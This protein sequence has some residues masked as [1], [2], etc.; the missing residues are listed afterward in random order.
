MKIIPIINY[1]DTTK[2]A[3][4]LERSSLDVTYSGEN[5]NTVHDDTNEVPLRE[6]ADRVSDSQEHSQLNSLDLTE[7]VKSPNRLEGL[8]SKEDLLDCSKHIK[9]TTDETSDSAK[10][11]DEEV[12]V[13]K[14]GESLRE[15]DQSVE[16]KSDTFFFFYY[17]HLI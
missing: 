13:N 9:T 5:I 12:L 8:I 1:F 7:Y 10:N 17:I 6:I 4:T 15:V 14:N 11:N 16:N 3:K 2:H